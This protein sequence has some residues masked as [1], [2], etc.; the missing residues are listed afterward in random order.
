MGVGECLE[1]EKYV[2]CCWHSVDDLDY[3]LGL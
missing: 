1:A 3:V 2:E